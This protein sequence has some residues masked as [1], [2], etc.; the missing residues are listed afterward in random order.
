MLEQYLMVECGL[1]G[2][3]SILGESVCMGVLFSM[4]N[5]SRCGLQS[6]ALVMSVS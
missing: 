2:R 3:G 5:D 6:D 4:V 1:N